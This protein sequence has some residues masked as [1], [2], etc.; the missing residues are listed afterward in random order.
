[1]VILGYFGTRPL[2][3]VGTIVSQ[4]GTLLYFAFFALMP[5][6]SKMD[7]CKPEPERLT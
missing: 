6:Y 7:R 4:V 3:D 5:W 2:T 1:F